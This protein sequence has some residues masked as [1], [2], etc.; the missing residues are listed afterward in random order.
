MLRNLEIKVR[1]PDL[2]G[3]AS[4]ARNLGAADSGTS[5]ATDTYFRAT[6]GR[7]KLREIEGEPEAT[8]IAYHRPDETFS[9]YSDYHLVHVVDVDTLQAA[10]TSTLGVLAA[11]WSWRPC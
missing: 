1:Y 5:R 9:R 8:L 6:H 3:A 10:L 7:L 2:P 11:S 4:R